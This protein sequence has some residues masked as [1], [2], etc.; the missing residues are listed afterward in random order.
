MMVG[1]TTSS[2]YREFKNSDAYRNDIV[3]MVFVPI[4]AQT[5]AIAAAQ[6]QSRLSDQAYRWQSANTREFATFSL[7]G[8]LFALPSDSVVEAVEAS[9]MSS[10]A[11]LRP[12]VAGVLNY[13]NSGSET[14]A[15]VPVVDMRYLIDSGTRQPQALNEVIVIRHGPHLLGLLV[16]RLHDVLEFSEKEIEP[17]L[18]LFQDRPSY[19]CNLIKPADQGR[20][21]QVLDFERLVQLVFGGKKK[22]SVVR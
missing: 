18:R 9:G 17:A 20:M 10:A 2:G 21:I 19:V 1:N 13:Q 14:S 12:L 15:F 7:D 16:G 3:A 22:L 6:E 11:A 4:G 8:T 5:E